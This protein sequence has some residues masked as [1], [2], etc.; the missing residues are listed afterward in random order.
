MFMRRLSVIAGV[1]IGLAL[2]GAAAPVGGNDVPVI[3]VKH[4]KKR[5]FKRKHGVK[6][7]AAKRH[8]TKVRPAGVRV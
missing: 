5:K 8:S 1:I 7:R 4:L 3:Q 2:P 6:R